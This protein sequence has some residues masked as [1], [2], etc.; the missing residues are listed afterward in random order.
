MLTGRTRRRRL[1]G[2]GLNG[3][4]SDAKGSGV[5][6]GFGI[7]GRGRICMIGIGDGARGDPEDTLS[8][9]GIM[10]V[11]SGSGDTGGALLE[12]TG[13]SAVDGLYTDVFLL[14][15]AFRSIRRLG[16]EEPE[17]G[18]VL[19]C[20]WCT[21]SGGVPVNARGPPGCGADIPCWSMKSALH[22][23]TGHLSDAFLGGWE[24]PFV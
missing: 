11:N 24:D 4:P 15:E 6:Q 20:E 2:G 23:G 13:G 14:M 17:Q 5:A 1:A 16:L 8:P 22:S 9:T 7:W 10:T 21:A 12:Y 19:C 18:R 3:T